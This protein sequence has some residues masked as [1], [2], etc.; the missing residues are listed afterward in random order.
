MAVNDLARSSHFW[1]G[2]ECR[3]AHPNPF[4]QTPTQECVRAADG[5]LKRSH[6][7]VARRQF[8]LQSGPDFIAQPILRFGMIGNPRQLPSYDC[9]GDLRA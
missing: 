8:L 2:E 4:H 6:Q 7:I 5:F 3:R 1:Q 9:C